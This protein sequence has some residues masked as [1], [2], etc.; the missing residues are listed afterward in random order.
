MNIGTTEAIGMQEDGLTTLRTATR[1]DSALV[2]RLLLQLGDRSRYL[3]Y[4]VPWRMSGPAAQH[5]AE[6]MLADAGGRVA[7]LV[8]RRRD[9]TDEAVA[10]GELA[11][12]GNRTAEV[13]LL[14]RDDLQRRGIGG[15]L[16]R[17]LLA[18]AYAVGIRRVRA[19]VLAENRPA[20]HLLR[21]LGFDHQLGAT[22]G[23]LQFEAN[24]DP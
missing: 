12:T 18:R 3:R 22:Y 1:A 8:L 9:G 6:R 24:L 5:E 16:G 11:P 20:R 23:M 4:H 15:R 17:A 19:D 13:A 2:A 10:V 21:R 14:V 7:L